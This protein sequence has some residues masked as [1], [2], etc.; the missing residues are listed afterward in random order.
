MNHRQRVE[1]VRTV[2]KP[3]GVGNPGQVQREPAAWLGG[4]RHKGGVTLH[5]ALVWNVGTVQRQLLWPL[6]DNYF[7]RSRESDSDDERWHEDRRGRDR[8]GQGLLR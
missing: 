7:G 1:S 4:T 6:D 2:S 3:G 8:C 5:Q